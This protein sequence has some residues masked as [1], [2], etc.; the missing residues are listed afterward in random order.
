MEQ[1]DLIYVWRHLC[2]SV[3]IAHIHLYMCVSV[4]LLL[5]GAS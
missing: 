5:R 3:I 2:V 4:M 1:H